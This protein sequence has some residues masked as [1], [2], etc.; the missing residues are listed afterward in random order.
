MVNTNQHS[1]FKYACGCMLVFLHTLVILFVT[2]TPFVS[3]NPYLL[4]TIIMINFVILAG[5]VVFGE[6]VCNAYENY[7]LGRP[8]VDGKNES[9]TMIIPSFICGK[10]YGWL[11]LTL[12]PLLTTAICYIK[13]LRILRA[14]NIKLF[15]L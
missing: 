7:L 9:I 2:V 1:N 3:N 14:K 4:L 10:K 5:W 11:F 12:F 8:K 13:L 6:C 15:A